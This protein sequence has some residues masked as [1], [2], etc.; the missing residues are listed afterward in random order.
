MTKFRENQFVVCGGQEFWQPTNAESLRSAKMIASKKYQ[1]AVDG[2]IE[3]GVV[4][5]T[6][7]Q[8]RI[9]QVAV[10]HGCGEWKGE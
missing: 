2:K 1:V 8:Q 7:E 5:G 6:G 3:V 4:V 9:E 10:K